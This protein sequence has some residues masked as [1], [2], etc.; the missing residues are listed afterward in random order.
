MRTKTWLTVVVL[1]V[2]GAAGAS[3]LAARGGAVRDDSIETAG[4]SAAAAANAGHLLTATGGYH[5][6]IPADFNGGI[7]GTLTD[8]KNRV[9][10]NAKK[11]A[12]GSVSGWWTYEQEVD[13]GVFKFGGPVTCLNIYDTPVLTRTPDIPPMT[14][15]RAKWGGRVEKSND[16]TIPV[17][18]FMWFQSIDNGEGANGYSDV[19]TLVG[20]GDEAANIAFC[21]ADRVPNSNFGPHRIGG[22][23]IQ[24]D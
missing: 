10:F 11:D 19:S 23:N 14:Q 9:T 7:F 18:R 16:E 6:T 5:F 8:I 2:S 12:D 22:G 13:G 15:N 21:N 4:A 3:A 20:L 17:G 24:V 1:V